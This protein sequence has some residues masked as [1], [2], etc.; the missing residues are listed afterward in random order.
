MRATAAAILLFIINMIGLGAGPMLFGMLSDGF[1]NWHLAQTG[2]DLT[3]ATCKTVAQESPL[4]TTC[5]TNQIEGLRNALYWSTG[6][7]VLS[8]A[9]FGLVILTIRRDMES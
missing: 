6:V 4:F 7:H 5:F 8:I 3:I 9:C 1:A 2:T